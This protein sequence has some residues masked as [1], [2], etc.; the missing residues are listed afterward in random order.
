MQ[1]ALRYAY[2]AGAI[3]LILIIGIIVA[4]IFHLLLDALYI[5][6]MLL[7]ALLVAATFLQLY[8]VIALIRTITTVREEMKPLLSSVEQTVGIVKDTAKTAGHTVSSIGAISQLTTEFVLGPGIRIAAGI[9]AGQQMLRVLLGKG[10]VLSRYEERRRQQM[11]AGA[12]GG[13]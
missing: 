4:G 11:E 10:R 12:G 2:I 5:L 8:W 7:A 6:L 9:V 13:Q 3:L 1:G